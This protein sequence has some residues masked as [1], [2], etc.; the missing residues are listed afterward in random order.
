VEMSPE[1]LAREERLVC[2]L[3]RLLQAIEAGGR[4][5]LPHTNEALLQSIVEAAAR[6]FGAA[7]ASIALVNETTHSLEFR[8]AYGAGQDQIMGTSIPLD[9][10]IIGYVAMSGQ[11]IAVSNVQQDV[12]F[13]RDFAQST[14]YVPRSILAM[15]LL[16]GERVIGVMEVLDKIA[17]PSFGLQDMELLGLFAR[18]AALAIAQAQLMDR[19]GEAFVLGLQRLAMANDS[20]DLGDALGAFQ[21]LGSE[22]EQ[23]R[24][25][26][27]LA[28]LLNEIGALGDAERRACVRVLEAFAECGRSRSRL[29]LV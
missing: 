7:A 19:M 29:G 27:A 11:P 1:E 10:G 3:H 8:V 20:A 12:R 22:S 21:H 16:S 2:Q 26:L 18:Q 28:D 17:A 25:L 9:K 6:I 15:P 13:S 4:A 5:L 24:D 23:S 14:G